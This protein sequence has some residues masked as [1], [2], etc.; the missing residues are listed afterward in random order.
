MPTHS[1][2]SYRF[3]PYHYFLPLYSTLTFIVNFHTGKSLCDI[4]RDCCHHFVSERDLGR[5]AQRV[6]QTERSLMIPLAGT[7]RKRC[8]RPDMSNVLPEVST[9][10]PITSLLSNPAASLLFTQSGWPFYHCKLKRKPQC[11]VQLKSMIWWLY[12]M[13]VFLIERKAGYINVETTTEEYLRGNSN[14]MT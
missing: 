10:L 5:D 12:T 2:I 8:V 7:K 1:S 13:L 3:L 9:L 11:P 6:C 14:E 4:R